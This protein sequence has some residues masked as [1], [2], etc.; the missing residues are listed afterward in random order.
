MCTAVLRKLREL[1]GLCLDE[2]SA[3]PTELTFGSTIMFVTYNDQE[4]F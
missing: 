1:G 3:A 2:L 4:R